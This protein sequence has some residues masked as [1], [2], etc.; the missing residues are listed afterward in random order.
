MGVRLV[1]LSV[2]G[3]VL[4]SRRGLA[5]AHATG[6][7]AG[8]PAG[9]R[10]RRPQRRL[11][12]RGCVSI[13]CRRGV[14]FESVLS[15]GLGGAA[16]WSRCSAASSS[17]L[18]HFSVRLRV[19]FA[20]RDTITT[21]NQTARLRSI[22]TT[23]VA[24]R[25][26]RAARRLRRPPHLC[27]SASGSGFVLPQGIH[28]NGEPDRQTAKHHHH[29]GGAAPWS[30]CSAAS[31][32]SSLVHFSVRLRAGF[33]TRDTITTV[34]QTDR[35]RS[36]ITTSVA[37]RPGRAARRL[38]RPPHLYISASGAGFGCSS[39][40]FVVRLQ[41]QARRSSFVLGFVLGFVLKLL[42]ISTKAQSVIGR[43]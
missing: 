40:S 32:S 37:R 36:I 39:P 9:R 17:S 25:P 15:P 41:V 23:S 21:V 26:G 4:R 34:N 12:S 10:Q 24:R 27:I 16:P 29:V 30:R 43:Q 8:V 33:A 22:I 28:H 14:G 7:E 35:L 1:L 18:V 2:E 11:V 3:V 42:I 13:E 5:A 38:R 6:C 31:S 19:R 20:T